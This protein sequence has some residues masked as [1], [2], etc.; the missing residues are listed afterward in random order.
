MTRMSLVAVLILSLVPACTT[1]PMLLR[2]SYRS[3]NVAPSTTTLPSSNPPIANQPGMQ[4]SQSATTTQ[5]FGVTPPFASNQAYLQ[6]AT[7][8]SSPFPMLA[9]ANAQI[10]GRS[11]PYLSRESGV[12]RARGAKMIKSSA[13]SSAIAGGLS[14]SP[15]EDL[16]YRGGHTIKDLKYINIFVGGKEL[17]DAN[18]WQSIDK[19]LDSAMS[20]ERLNN[21]VMQYF[22]NQPI[23]AEFLGSFF[24][25]AWKPKNVQKADLQAQIRVLDQYK[26]FDGRDLRNTVFNFILPRGTILGDPSGGAQQV[27]INKAI[28]HEEA[29]DSTGGLGGY[30][31]SVHLG[32]KTI[33]YSVNVYSER[34]ANG[35]TNGIPV[36]NANWKN[37]VA[38]LYH[39]LHEARTDPDVEDANTH[40]ITALGWTSDT[41]NEIG[42]YPIAEATQLLQVFKEVDLADGSGTVPIQLNYSNAV[43]GPEGPIDYPHGKE[44]APGQ[45]T[46]SPNNNPPSNKVPDELTQLIKNWDQ[47]EDYIRK[48]ILKLASP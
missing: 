47:Y 14:A 35:A 18:D 7:I 5:S 31:G 38:T 42:D 27:V 40:G 48:A 25:S 6:G 43:H 26:N 29:E 9:S 1:D 41:G 4:L 23:S 13:R 8:G 32:A 33:Y 20:D 28:P 3:R 44:P 19:A 17:W 45:P 16:R 15:Q 11:M 46:N 12:P 37:V 24:L 36:F 34:Q 10:D 21:V 2:S 30:H 22:G 39:E